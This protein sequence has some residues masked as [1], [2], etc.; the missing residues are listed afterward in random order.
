MKASRPAPGNV[1]LAIGTP[2][3]SDR[4]PRAISTTTHPVFCGIIKQPLLLAAA[5]IIFLA[6]LIAGRLAAPLWRGPQYWFSSGKPVE[7]VVL[8]KLQREL[9]LTPAQTERIAPFIALSCA[10][11]RL[12]SEESRARRLAL[13]DEIGATIAPDLTTTQRRRLEELEAE[14]QKRPSKHEERVVAMY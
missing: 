13:M 1:N 7:S 9:Q 3:A 6:G 2:S 8:A 12:L 10:K 4:K 11:L 14:W 5:V